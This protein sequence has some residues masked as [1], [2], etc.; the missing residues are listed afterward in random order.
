MANN[1][2]DESLQD[3]CTWLSCKIK[4]LQSDKP[5]WSIVFCAYNEE[6]YL[7]PTIKS[8]SAISTTLPIEIIA[9]NNAST[10]RTREILEQCWVKVIDEKQKWLSYARNA[11]LEAAEWELIFQTDADTKVPSTWVDAHNR[12]YIDEGIWWV[13][14]RIEFE[15]VCMLYYLYRA[16][17]ISYH[18]LLGM[19]WKAPLC[20]WW[21]NL[22]YRKEKVISMWWFTKW[23]DNGEDI[24]LFH[25]LSKVSKTVIDMSKKV[26]VLTNW[27]RY[28]KSSQIVAHIKKKFGVMNE[29]IFSSDIIPLNQGFEDVR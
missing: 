22:S 25:K 3:E 17:A 1:L 29:R 24:L 27:R 20:T 18:F 13:S 11:W 5:H 14:W 23:C 10:D 21:A 26:N 28:E 2:K 6:D 12:N 16:W 15:D 9:V 7:I 19:I 8:I 4:E